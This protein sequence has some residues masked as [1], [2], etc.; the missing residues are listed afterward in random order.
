MGGIPSGP[1]VKLLLSFLIAQMISASSKLTD[2]KPMRLRDS[3]SGVIR[4]PNA[5]KLS[6]AGFFSLIM[7]VIQYFTHLSVVR[8]EKNAG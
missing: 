2:S 8:G 4:T 7:I 1:H 6:V 5:R 3:Q